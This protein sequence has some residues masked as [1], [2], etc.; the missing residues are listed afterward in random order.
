MWAL[1]IEGTD[2]PGRLTVADQVGQDRM[3][4]EYFGALC[5]Y[6]FEASN[7]NEETCDVEVRVCGLWL[8]SE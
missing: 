1:R 2:W 8:R 6:S 3:F 4:G 7:E 5:E